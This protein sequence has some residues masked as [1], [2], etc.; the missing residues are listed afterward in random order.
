MGANNFFT[1]AIGETIDEAFNTAVVGARLWHGHGGYTGT[2][3]EKHEF[4][5]VSL[6]PRWTARKLAGLLQLA[7]P[8]VRGE[9]EMAIARPLTEHFSAGELRQLVEQY[10]DEWSPALGVCLRPA[11]AKRVIAEQRTRVRRTLTSG[12]SRS[13]K[14]FAF[15][16]LAS[17]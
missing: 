8:T 12:L 17:C 2:I 15:F 5:L 14:V 13:Q 9:T 3:A 11:E 6:P 16:G 7:S 1:Y 4:V 10:H